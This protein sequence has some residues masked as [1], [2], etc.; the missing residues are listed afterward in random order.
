MTP[1]KTSA[2][3]SHYLLKYNTQKS[4]DIMDI[5]SDIEKIISSADIKTGTVT[6]FTKHTT[7]AIK[8]NENEAGFFKDFRKFCAA[9]APADKAYHHNDLENRDPATM[10]DGEE[11]LNG[12][13]HLL[14]MFVG[15]ASET[16]PV[17]D[18]EMQLGTW[19]R[20]LFIELDHA[21]E[22]EVMVTLMGE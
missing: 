8:I 9:F 21:R 4:L 13:S 20:I 7:T 12:H 6:I 11:C 3:V 1:Y 19:Q 16:I 17:I 15:T 18:G 2:T 10:C 22:R 14:Q 5:T